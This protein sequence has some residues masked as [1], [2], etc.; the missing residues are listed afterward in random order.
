[1]IIIIITRIIIIKSIMIIIIIIITSI[2]IIKSIMI[3]IIIII[4][5]IIMQYA[6]LYVL[7]FGCSF[8]S[9]VKGCSQW[10]IGWM[11]HDDV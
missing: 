7:C 11:D 5:S 10:M 3:I 2:I 9:F 4:K 6:P 8:L 1:M